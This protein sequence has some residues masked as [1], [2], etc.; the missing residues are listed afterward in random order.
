MS[1]GLGSVDFD[2][3]DNYGNP[4]AADNAGPKFH[5]AIFSPD[6]NCYR[7]FTRTV[8]HETNSL[9]PMMGMQKA[10]GDYG[11][12]SGY[13]ISGG[14]SASWGGDNGIEF[15]GYFNGEIHDSKGNSAEVHVEQKNDGNG[16]VDFS[17]HH[18]DKDSDQH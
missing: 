1:I 5:E 6:M 3:F 13:S 4:F 2:D 10:G 14:G 17:V 15:K 11:K 8:V 9:K 16:R 7:Q 12:D 18:E